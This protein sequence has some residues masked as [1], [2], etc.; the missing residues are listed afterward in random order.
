MTVS[1]LDIIT[2]K[3]GLQK[4]RSIKYCLDYVL[5]HKHTIVLLYS[6]FKLDLWTACW[7]FWL[8]IPE[9]IASFDLEYIM[10]VYIVCKWSEIIIYRI[11]IYSY[12]KRCLNVSTYPWDLVENKLGW[13]FGPPANHRWNHHT[14]THLRNKSRTEHFQNQPY[15]YQIRSIAICYATSV[16]IC[17]NLIYHD[18]VSSVPS[19]AK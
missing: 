8:V 9:V 7:K 14:I 2:W 5:H 10:N 18:V 12:V 16:S 13:K 15:N 11:A 17:L 3:F 1:V 19:K 4:L 6:R